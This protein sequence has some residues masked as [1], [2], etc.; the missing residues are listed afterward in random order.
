MFLHSLEPQILDSVPLNHPLRGLDL[1]TLSDERLA[2]G[3][4]RA[5]LPAFDR[6]WSHNGHADEPRA[7]L[8]DLKDSA[9]RRVTRVLIQLTRITQLS[10][11][12][13]LNLEAQD[14]LLDAMTL[15]FV[16][17]VGVFDAI[18]IANGLLAGQT[19]YRQMGWQKRGFQKIM[20][21]RS[22]K[23]MALLE[24]RT[25]G[26]KFLTAILSFRNTIHRRMPDPT[27][28][29][30][31]NGDPALRHAGLIL[32]RRSHGEILDAFEAVGWTKFVGVE[33]IGSDYLLLNP[34]T[35]MRLMLHDGIPLIN[36][37]V[38]ATH[39]EELGARPRMID[40][41]NTLYPRQL[42]EYAVKYLR[43]KYL[44][45]A[46]MKSREVL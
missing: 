46:N 3:A 8:L 4:A 17:M 6:V 45:V 14:D 36:S 16:H 11:R 9:L 28:V 43:L 44:D 30:L 26:G 1:R 37:V 33:L 27:A 39:A 40:Y 31:E 15:A 21:R 19:E 12:R 25:D 34:K 38:Y 18:A 20:R 10:E 5:I 13:D 7:E 42:Q 2:D 23:A 32:E 22:P 24:P 35:V 41:D 29:G